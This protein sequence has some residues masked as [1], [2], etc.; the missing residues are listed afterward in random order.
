MLRKLS[1]GSNVNKEKVKSLKQT[2]LTSK[3]LSSTPDDD[4]DDVAVISNAT[5]GHI[6]YGG[7]M[8][9]RGLFEILLFIFYYFLLLKQV[10]GIII[11]R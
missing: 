9:S 11:F 7:S 1:F 10:V 8:G 5:Q 2:T 6:T 3:N 4:L